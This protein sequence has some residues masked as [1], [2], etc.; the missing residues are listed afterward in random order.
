MNQI[1]ELKRARHRSR[2]TQLLLAAVAAGAIALGGACSKK[3][4]E[5]DA[6]PPRLPAPQFSVQGG[7]FTNN[8]LTVSLMG[9]PP[10]AVIRYT[11][12]GSTPVRSSRK[13]SGPI[14]ITESTLLK[15]KVFGESSSNSPIAEQTY[16]LVSAD[17]VEFSSN[18]PLVI[19]NSFR[20][21]IPHDKKVMVSARV[22]DAK[23]GRSTVLGPTDYDGRA[24]LNIRGHT[25]LRYPKHSYHLK[26][27]DEQRNAQKA[28]ILGFPKDSDWVLYAPYP[29]KTLMRDVL[30]YELSNQMG[31]YAA[32]TRFVEVFLN[33]MGGKL[34]ARDYLGV[35]VFEEKI[36]RGKKRVNIEKLGPADNTEP[37]VSG[38]Y[39]FK[40]DHLDRIELGSSNPGGYPTG[41]GGGRGSSRETYLSGPGGFPA[42]PEGFLRREG[43]TYR[44]TGGPFQGFNNLFSSGPAQAF[45]S[46]HDNHFFY[47]EPKPEEISGAQRSWLTRYV[48][49]CEEVLY[50]NNF[51]DPKTGYA[52]YLDADSFI[53]YHLMVELTKNID[54]FRFSTF[55][56][57]DRG[58]KIKMGPIWDWNLSFGQSSG[59]QGYLAE[60][61]YW[62]QLDD[63]QYTWFRRLFEDPDFGQR[64]V[65]RWGELRTNQFVV[66]KLHA[67]ID[68]LAEQLNEA[69][70][71]NFRRWP[72]LGRS[73]YP[74]NFVGMSYAAEVSHMKE[75]IQKRIEWI[76]RQF[77]AAPAFSIPAGA[78]ERGSQ[79]AL[80]APVGKIYYT[81]D[82]T[83]PRAAGG[84]VASGARTFE[85]P[86]TL[87][88]DTVVF[89]RAWQ[90]N[91]WSYPAGSKFIVTHA[92]PAHSE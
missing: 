15:A 90:D 54:G 1:G 64:Y 47:V 31:R 23:A 39:I 81:L 83:D 92:A 22:I 70:A 35:F 82:G 27:R 65:D 77:L 9:S 75:W 74:N 17:L 53:D 32:R 4:A 62:P 41:G 61:W 84:A 48:N 51:K 57:K 11:L 59:K 80:R 88:K 58:G 36:E 30:G 33:E 19:L 13:Y 37:N 28:S 55:Y 29:D 76:D 2:S 20:Q 8:D 79:L 18:L 7:I 56:T 67:R 63:Q 85:D 5:K 71:R 87:E 78:I 14:T 86:L 69:Q 34:S 26:T 25:S 60:Y 43:Q 10:T 12:D 21:S 68:E 89:C 24:D 72:I 3:S 45:D 52:A 6:T 46:S 38:G 66:A 50:G 40:K 91:R 44:K 49:K 73:V 16:V 42:H